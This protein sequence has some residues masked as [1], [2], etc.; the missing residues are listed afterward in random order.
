MRRTFL[1]LYAFTALCAVA[2][3]VAPAAAAGPMSEE[4]ALATAVS[5]LQGDPYGDTP[6]TVRAGIFERRLGPRHDTVCKQ[7][8]D[9]QTWSFHVVVASPQT[10]PGGKIDGWLVLDAR[11]GRIVCATLPFLD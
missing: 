1:P 5:I 2:S 9:R 8:A 4:K 7:G 3:F 11:T 6:Q 10:Q